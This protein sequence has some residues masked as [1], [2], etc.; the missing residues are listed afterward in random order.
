MCGRILIT[1]LL[2]ALLASCSPSEAEVQAEF[3]AFVTDHATCEAD[4]D[5][6]VFSPGCPLGCWV[7]VRSDALDEAEALADD[8]IDD[9]VRGGTACAY[10]C[11]AGGAATCLA[12]QCAL[13]SDPGASCAPAESF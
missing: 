13:C 10:E 6:A 2:G 12:G 8:L 7:A 1:A 9:Y 4:T 11:V 5:C 3:D